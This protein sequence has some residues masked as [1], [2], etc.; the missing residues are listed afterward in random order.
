MKDP[1]PLIELP[2]HQVRRSCS[3]GVDSSSSLPS[4]S[5]MARKAFCLLDAAKGTQ[6][7]TD[8]DRVIFSEVP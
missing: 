4:G 1:N 3:A 7:K 5:G 2:I 8:V 6:F